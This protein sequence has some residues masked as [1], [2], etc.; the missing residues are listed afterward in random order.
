MLTT[1]W[2]ELDKTLITLEDEI[3]IENNPRKKK[4]LEVYRT[5]MAENEKETAA[6]HEEIRLIR[7]RDDNVRHVHDEIIL[8]MSNINTE[9]DESCDISFTNI[10]DSYSSE[11]FVCD[12]DS[13]KRTD[14][15]CSSVDQ[16]LCCCGCDGDA[17]GSSHRC[18]NTERRA[19]AYCLTG[20]EGYGSSSFCRGCACL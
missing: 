2:Q 13:S 6:I 1:C 5:M 9:N 3:D 19:M 16:T 20:E 11:D 17:S 14:S 15:S 18:S 7:A 10:N 8:D 12:Q 4:R